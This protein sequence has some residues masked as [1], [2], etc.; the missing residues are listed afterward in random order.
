MKTP[1]AFAI[2]AL[3]WALAAP[4]QAQTVT[5]N[6][7]IGTQKAL[8]VIDGEPHSVAVGA[9]VRGVRL[10]SLG[11]AQAEV[12]VAGA[13]RSLALGAGAVRAGAPTRTGGNEIVLPAGRN[14]H[15]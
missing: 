13:R 1:I 4:A 8:L 2:A 10:L 7:H 11:Q 3:C 6:G 14:G 5:L 9:V 12:E 15:F